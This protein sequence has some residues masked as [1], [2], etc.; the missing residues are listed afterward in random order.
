[1]YDALMQ[2][3]SVPFDYMDENWTTSQ[4]FGLLAAVIESER[5]EKRGPN[6]AEYGRIQ[7]VKK[8]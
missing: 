1:M 8:G 7:S 4:M 5:K 2:R 6:A 3:Y